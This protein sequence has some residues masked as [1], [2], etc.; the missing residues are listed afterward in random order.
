M[1]FQSIYLSIFLSNY[2]S[3]YQYI[4]LS[5]TSH[6]II[7]IYATQEFCKKYW[8]RFTQLNI[9]RSLRSLKDKSSYQEDGIMVAYVKKRVN[10][11]FKGVPAIPILSWIFKQYMIYWL[12]LEYLFR[13]PSA[14]DLSI[15]CTHIF[16]LLKYFVGKGGGLTIWKH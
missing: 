10:G 5:I 1:S 16:N 13:I 7:I 9:A 11:L 8:N 14:A 4:F 12:K 15:Y 2:L 3:I 6:N